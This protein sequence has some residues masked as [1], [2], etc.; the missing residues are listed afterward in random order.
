LDVTK[1]VTFVKIFVI[2]VNLD[3][4]SFLSKS[5]PELLLTTASPEGTSPDTE[6]FTKN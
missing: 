5:S 1:F 3:S 6:I 2:L 4:S